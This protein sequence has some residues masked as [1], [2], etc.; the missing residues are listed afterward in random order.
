MA[1][2]GRYRVLGYTAKL[3]HWYKVCETPAPG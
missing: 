1:E 2:L 3:A